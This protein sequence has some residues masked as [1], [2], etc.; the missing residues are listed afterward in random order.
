M[1]ATEPDGFGDFIAEEEEFNSLPSITPKGR[2]LGSRHDESFSHQVRSSWN[3]LTSVSK[4]ILSPPAAERST[5]PDNID[6]STQQKTLGDYFPTENQSLTTYTD[7]ECME[8]ARYL[9]EDNKTAWSSIPRIYIVLRLIG[10]LHTIESFVNGGFNDLW[11]PFS[12]SSLPNTLTALDKERFLETQSRVLSKALELESGGLKRHA[13]FNREDAFPFQSRGTLGQGA[14]ATVDRIYSPISGK[15]YARKRFRRTKVGPKKS[16]VQS[17]KTELQVLKRIQHIHCVEL[18]ASYT[19]SKYF[20]LIMTPVADCNLNEFYEL[21]SKSEEDRAT[22][23]TFFGCLSTALC[24]LHENKIRHRDIKPQNVLVRKS[25]VYLTDFGISLDWGDLTR[26][27]TTAD[28]AK[29]LMY[30]APEVA[31]YEKR[32][33]SSDIY[34]LGAIFVEMLTL[35]KGKV[36]QDLRQFISQNGDGV[37]Y[38]RNTKWAMAW[39]ERLTEF[40]NMTDNQIAAW[41]KSTLQHE[42][43]ARISASELCDL[44]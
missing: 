12:H 30:C 8:I 39:V 23:R 3:A 14:Y 22:L 24:Y 11:F 37:H 13:H 16:E 2:I 10:L 29:T 42:P 21:A 28:S 43:A 35:L 7:G 38:F 40:G 33:S 31:Y 25:T 6:V 44:I 20:G 5:R 19:D 34:S 15:E 18:V 26:G 4:T 32:N 1:A 36:I 27:T 41:I 9:R 17:F